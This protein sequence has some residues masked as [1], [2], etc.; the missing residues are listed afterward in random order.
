M[1]F[2]S[3]GGYFDWSFERTIEYLS[4]EDINSFELS[5]GAYVPDIESKLE[6][7]SKNFNIRLHNYFPQQ[8]NPSCLI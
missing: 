8:N 5:G 4:K 7:F 2:V 1:I 3:T 6:I